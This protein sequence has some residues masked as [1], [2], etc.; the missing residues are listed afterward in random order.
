M[1]YSAVLTVV[2]R[3]PFTNC[4]LGTLGTVSSANS[5]GAD[6]TLQSFSMLCKVPGA[7]RMGRKFPC[8]GSSKTKLRKRRCPTKWMAARDRVV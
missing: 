8:R 2:Y 3:K 7:G 6:V 1:S 5:P 4:A